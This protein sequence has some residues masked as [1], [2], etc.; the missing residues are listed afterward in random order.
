MARQNG[1]DRKEDH[2]EEDCDVVNQARASKIND[3]GNPPQMLDAILE[4]G[5]ADQRAVSRQQTGELAQER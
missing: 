5:G 3:S 4:C 1:K 2:F